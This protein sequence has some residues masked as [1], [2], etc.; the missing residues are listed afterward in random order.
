MG[1]ERIERWGPRRIDLDLI[2]YGA[3]RIQQDDLTVPH[4]GA[5]SRNFVLYPLCDF[6]P[7]VLLPGHG[8]L[9][10]LAAR[11]EASG[12]APVQQSPHSLQRRIPWQRIPNSPRRIG[13]SWS[14]GPSASARPASR[15]AW[16]AASAAT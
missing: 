1:R 2:M 10:A 14:K 5:A 9:S 3:A 12:L 15:G 8:R 11:V 4:P 7:S 13:S 16:P 6:A